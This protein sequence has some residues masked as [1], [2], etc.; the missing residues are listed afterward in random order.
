MIDNVSYVSCLKTFPG[1]RVC[2]F[3]FDAMFALSLVTLLLI[4]LFHAFS[5]ENGS[6]YFTYQ[7][8]ITCRE[9]KYATKDL[10]GITFWNLSSSMV[11][12][13]NKTNKSYLRNLSS[14]ITLLW[15]LNQH[16]YSCMRKL[17]QIDTGAENDGDK[18][19]SMKHF[20]FSGLCKRTINH[21]SNDSLVFQQNA[22]GQFSAIKPY[23]GIV[24]DLRTQSP[25]VILQL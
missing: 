2:T 20:D 19:T 25:S 22:S 7:L 3:C 14:V 12:H 21:Q 1:E 4:A 5:P 13:P 9:F 10:I 6:W 23:L 8:S 24:F 15:K 17:G 11:H 18:K 16:R